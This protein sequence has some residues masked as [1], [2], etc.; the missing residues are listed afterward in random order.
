MSNLLDGTVVMPK[1]ETTSYVIPQH[2]EKLIVDDGQVLMMIGPK[3]PTLFPLLS[4]NKDL[5]KDMIDVEE[6]G[7]KDIKMLPVPIPV[8]WRFGMEYDQRWALSKDSRFV[9]CCDREENLF[10]KR[11]NLVR[12]DNTYWCNSCGYATT[13]VETTSLDFMEM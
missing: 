8:P 1:V 5:G 9:H 11:G 2:E 10:P 13:E 4:Q 12:R 3:H 6:T 7:L